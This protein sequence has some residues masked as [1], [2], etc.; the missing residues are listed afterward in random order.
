[1][2]QT[3]FKTLAPDVQ[4]NEKYARA[5]LDDL[6]AE[7]TVTCQVFP[8]QFVYATTGWQ[9]MVSGGIQEDKLNLY[10]GKL[11]DQR[12]LDYPF[13]K[14]V[15]G[16][17]ASKRLAFPG[18][19]PSSKRRGHDWVLNPV[20]PEGEQSGSPVE[21]SA[22]PAFSPSPVEMSAEPPLTNEA[23]WA[24][25][26]DLDDNSGRDS[27]LGSQQQPHESIISNF[28]WDTAAF[29][30]SDNDLNLSGFV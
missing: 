16:H 12:V 9:E 28:N 26:L 24:L 13:T 11:I 19:S 15:L 4:M 14:N 1:M 25:L 10:E 22:G 8:A 2:L 27:G 17:E 20:N 6:L 3:M 7:K 18:S 23:L 5:I 29:S 21:K 30:D